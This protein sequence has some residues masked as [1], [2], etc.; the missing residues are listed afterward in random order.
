MC[1]GGVTNE[2]EKKIVGLEGGGGK[3]LVNIANC[4][5]LNHIV[6]SLMYNTV[7]CPGVAC[8]SNV[9]SPMI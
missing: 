9:Q 1:T 3:F 5:H 7:N 2:K 8:Q 4:S 6:E